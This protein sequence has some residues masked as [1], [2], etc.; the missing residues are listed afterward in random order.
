MFNPRRYREMITP[1]PPPRVFKEYH[2]NRAADRH[3]T[4][5]T[6]ALQWGGNSYMDFDSKSISIYGN[7]FGVEMD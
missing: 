2:A 6:R 4:W 1:P 3:E 5:Y 7:G